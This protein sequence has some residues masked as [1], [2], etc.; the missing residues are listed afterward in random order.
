M[1][2]EDNFRHQHLC[3]QGKKLKFAVDPSCLGLCD[4]QASCY[5]FL[6][7]ES[8]ACGVDV[9]MLIN[10]RR[11]QVMAFHALGSFISFCPTKNAALV[12]HLRS[13]LVFSLL[14]SNKL[15]QQL[16]FWMKYNK[17][18]AGCEDSTSCLMMLFTVAVSF[19]WFNDPHIWSDGLSY[20]LS[21]LHRVQKHDRLLQNMEIMSEKSNICEQQNKKDGF[22][23]MHI[24]GYF[25]SFWS[26]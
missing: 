3:R 14:T 24:C 9:L 16:I 22:F 6:L 12:Q 21:T 5:I 4:C 13:W 26:F 18:F 15:M 19:F 7:L 25:G 8:L 10:F 17:K 23:Q 20:F 2:S 11:L 1:D